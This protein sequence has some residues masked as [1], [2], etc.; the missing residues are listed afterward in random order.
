M[1]E[2][3]SQKLE[4]VKYRGN[5]AQRKRVI[6]VRR[7]YSNHFWG[8]FQLAIS[9]L[10]THP[11]TVQQIQNDVSSG[12]DKMTQNFFS[13][14]LQRVWGSTQ[15]NCRVVGSRIV[16]PSG[17]TVQPLHNQITITSRPILLS[18]CVFLVARDT[19]Q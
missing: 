6:F 15:K 17:S 10:R 5:V 14:L 2:E 4:K 3:S 16:Q 12:L 13:P 9:D 11:C 19:H 7:G 1:R 18:C 8:E